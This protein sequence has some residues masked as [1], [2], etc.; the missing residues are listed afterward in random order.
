M[1]YYVDEDAESFEFWSGAKEN[2]E[3]ARSLGTEVQ[4][5]ENL[6]DIFADGYVSATDINDYVWFQMPGDFPELFGEEDEEEDEE[7]D[8][9]E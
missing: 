6:E 2:I 9:G 7:E 3:K 1:R 4:V 8:N 5:F